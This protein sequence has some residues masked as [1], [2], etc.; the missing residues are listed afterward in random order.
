MFRKVLSSYKWIVLMG[1]VFG[2]LL[3]VAEEKVGVAVPFRITV[4]GGVQTLSG[5]KLTGMGIRGMPTLEV[6]SNQSP[7]VSL[8]GPSRGEGTIGFYGGNDW[9]GQIGYGD[10]CGSGVPGLDDA[11]GICSYIGPTTLGTADRTTL[12]VT[13]EGHV[14]IGTPNPSAPLH[15]CGSTLVEG[16]LVVSG[17]KQ[18]VH[19][20]PIDSGKEVVYVSLEG[21][22]V[23][24][25]VRG[26]AELLDGRTEIALPEHFAL[27]T[28]EEGC[29]VQLTP[30]GEWLQLYVVEKSVWRIVVQE[31]NGC[32][33]QFDYLV[34]G[35][36]A[37]YE[38]YSV[39]RDRE[40]TL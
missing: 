21:P 30:I 6:T 26:T 5:L 31:A 7:I 32:N 10:V 15:V 39:L 11:V 20:H 9:K 3:V 18:F 34:Q 23:G 40:E 1:M 12:F 8:A 24:T 14:G 4:P 16:D 29:T 19:Q 35:V 28:S 22:E 38:D 13:A 2:L 17:I 25:Y 27:V 33:G 36:R 37:G